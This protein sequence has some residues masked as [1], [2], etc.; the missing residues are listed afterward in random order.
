MDI[1]ILTT[2]FMWCTIINGTVFALWATTCILMPD[3]LFRIHSKWFSISRETF[4]ISIYSFL[5]ILKIF[6]LVFNVAPYVALL[7][8]G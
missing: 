6:F 5:G 8:M 2:F 1:Q 3:L 4:N 7:I